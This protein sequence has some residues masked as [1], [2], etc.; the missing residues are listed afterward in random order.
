MADK[1]VPPPRSRAT[2]I[3]PA[4]VPLQGAAAPLS[5]S[6]RSP[7]S[8]AAGSMK[9]RGFGKTESRSSQIGAGACPVCH[10]GGSPLA[11]TTPRAGTPDVAGD[12]AARRPGSVVS[13]ARGRGGGPDFEGRREARPRTLAH[14]RRGEPAE[15]EARAGE[16]CFGRRSDL[17]GGSSGQSSRCC[18]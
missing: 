3:L 5:R 4:P 10:Q 14:A 6:L 15:D 7:G 11:K 18:S 17:T 12:P 13:A 1:G 9:H 2:G 8:A 16:P